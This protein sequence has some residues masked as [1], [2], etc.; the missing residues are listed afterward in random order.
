MRVFRLERD[1]KP[2]HCD[3]ICEMTGAI[4]IFAQIM[5]M[6]LDARGFGYQTNGCRPYT[7]SNVTRRSVSMRAL[8]SL[9]R[10]HQLIFG[11][12]EALD[13]Y[14]NALDAKHPLVAGDFKALV[15][16]FRTFADYRHFEKEENILVPWLVRRGFDDNSGIL[17]GAR[18]EHQQLR[19]LI[20]VLYQSAER[21]LDWSRDERNRISAAARS[22]SEQQRQLAAQQEIELFPDILTRLPAHALDDLASELWQFDVRSE[23]RA[24]PL[25]VQELSRDVAGR[26]ADAPP[27]RPRAPSAS[28]PPPSS[29]PASTSR[30]ARCVSRPEVSRPEVSWPEAWPESVHHDRPRFIT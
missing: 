15:H 11:L 2:T 14:A 10:D 21:E 30:P 25:D 4:Q 6:C 7:T 20:D 9:H 28:P 3:A 19:Y 17:V 18:N 5:F 13:A 23:V 1:L 8:E 16:G 24:S 27:S 12:T 29:R 26:Y 22:L